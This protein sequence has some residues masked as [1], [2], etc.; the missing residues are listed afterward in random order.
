ML[1]KDGAADRDRP[2]HQRGDAEAELIDRPP[3]RKSRNQRGDES[4]ED[5]QN[6]GDIAEIVS[7]HYAD[8][9]RVPADI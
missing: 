1:G 8:P 5:R 6:G 2:D 9:E 4:V 3:V 7:P